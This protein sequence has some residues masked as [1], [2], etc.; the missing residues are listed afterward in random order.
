MRPSGMPVSNSLRIASV[1]YGAWSGVSTMPGWITLQRILSRANWMA[2]DFV[3]E[4]RAPLAAGDASWG[5][6]QP[7][8][9]GP[10]GEGARARQP[11]PARRLQLL[12]GLG[13]RRAVDVGHHDA[14]ALLGEQHRRLP[15]HPRA[16]PRDERDLAAQPLSQ[17]IHHSPERSKRSRSEAARNGPT[18]A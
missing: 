10:H 12:A 18:E 6:V 7:V 1:R 8:A 4:V 2:G 17:S 3:R 14:R 9:V 11:R 13:G 16:R 5:P 15:P